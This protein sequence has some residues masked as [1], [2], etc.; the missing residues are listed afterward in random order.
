MLRCPPRMDPLL[1]MKAGFRP[2]SVIGRRV[3]FQSWA[4]SEGGRYHVK[5]DFHRVICY[6]L[7]PQLII[8]IKIRWVAGH[9]ELAL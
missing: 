8:L 4:N 1:A 9:E 3:H 7:G 6:T 2:R 5:T